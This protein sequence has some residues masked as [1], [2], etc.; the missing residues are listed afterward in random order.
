M[1]PKDALDE[2]LGVLFLVLKVERVS[3]IPVALPLSL[4]L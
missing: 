2:S 4:L 3:L 1:L